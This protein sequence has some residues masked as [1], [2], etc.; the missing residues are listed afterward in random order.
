MDENPQSAAQPLARL[1]VFFPIKQ[2]VSV[3]TGDWV[4]IRMTIEPTTLL[5]TWI[6]EIWGP[7]QAK[8]ARFAHSAFRGL[9]LSREDLQRMQPQFVPRLSSWGQ[10]RRTILE[11]CDGQRSVAAI[12]Q[13]LLCRHPHLFSS[14]RQ[15]AVFVAAVISQGVE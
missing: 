4:Q 5:V 1:Q 6:V 8:K 12:E 11:L 13:E 10:A 3:E 2:S 9:L 15:A 14:P 7:A